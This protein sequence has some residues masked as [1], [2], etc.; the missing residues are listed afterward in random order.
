MA[1]GVT[2]LIG[3]FK[4]EAAMVSVL[5]CEAKDADDASNIV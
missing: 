2:E 3:Q 5:V 1:M 4:A